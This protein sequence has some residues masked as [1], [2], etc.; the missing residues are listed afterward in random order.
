MIILYLTVFGIIVGLL[1]FGYTKT[2]RPTNLANPEGDSG[3]IGMVAGPVNQQRAA[4]I[5]PKII[6]VNIRTGQE[7]DK[8]HN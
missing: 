6:P 8:A 4:G 2:L 1:F 5:I 3:S 7:D